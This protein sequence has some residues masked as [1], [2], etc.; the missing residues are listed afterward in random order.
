MNGDLKK[1]EETKKQ[2][3]G[4]R[5]GSGRPPGSPNKKQS[6]KRNR[7]YYLSDDEDIAVKDFVQQLR[8][9]KQ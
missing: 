6:T 4:H 9:K 8:S 3:G 2:C 7:G 1:M 5:P